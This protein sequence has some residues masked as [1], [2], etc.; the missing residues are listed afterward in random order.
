MMYNYIKLDDDTQIA[1]SNILDDQTV[2]ISV[3][4]P[5]D[6]GFQSATCFLPQCRWVEVEGFTRQELARLADIVKSNSPLI[7]RLAR[8]AGKAYA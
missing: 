3:E 4:R 6:G 8:D 7:C 2:Q 5:I 1:Y